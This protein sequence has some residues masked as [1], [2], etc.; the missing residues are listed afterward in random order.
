MAQTERSGDFPA[1]SSRLYF[2]TAGRIPGAHSGVDEWGTGDVKKRYIFSAVPPA[3]WSARSTNYIGPLAAC[4][5]P[6]GLFARL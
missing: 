3:I 1:G 2:A 6:G 4:Q 5:I